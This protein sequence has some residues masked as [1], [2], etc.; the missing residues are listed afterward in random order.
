MP[1]Y[2]RKTVPPIDYDA[3]DWPPRIPG[4]ALVLAAVLTIPGIVFTWLYADLFVSAALMQGWQAVPA[5]ILRAELESHRGGKSGTTLEAVGE[6]AYTFDGQPYTSH[7]LHWGVG[8]DNLGSFQHDI[9]REMHEH[10]LSGQPL[11]CY[12]NPRRPEQAVL[13]RGPRPEM[14]LLL[15]VLDILFGLVFSVALPL[16]IVREYVRWRR[17]RNFCRRQTAAH[18]DEP[19]LWRADWAAGEI[20]A[21]GPSLGKQ[22]GPYA[23]AVNLL[24][25]PLWIF[26]P[27][28]LAGNGW[29][30][31][32]MVLIALGLWCGLLALRQLR[33]RRRWV[34]RLAEVPA[35]LGGYLAGEIETDA[36]ETADAPLRLKLAC[37]TD[38]TVKAERGERRKEQILWETTVPAGS[39]TPGRG[40][41]TIA[42]AVRI[43]VP[44]NMPAASPPA[45]VGRL[46]TVWRLTVESEPPAA[47][48]IARFE[49]PVFAVIDAR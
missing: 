3:D 7:K 21:A 29:A 46:R 32:D 34:L 35:L 36:Q 20:V 5:K 15:C 4:L 42:T 12:V 6:Y 14:A 1:G 38:E 19:W 9:F 48:P 43:A 47:K 39:A 37:V 13:Y 11:T 30:I 40:F 31:A 41:E 18:P 44:A 26:L 22:G 45:E 24:A 33:R 27:D 25:L 23:V 17:A 28:A 16:T 10:E 2:G 8:S 49:V